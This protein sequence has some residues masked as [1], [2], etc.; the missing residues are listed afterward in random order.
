MKIEIETIKPENSALG[1][2]QQK[3]IDSNEENSKATKKQN[4]IS[5]CIQV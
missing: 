2:M 3:M 4:R 1:Q 5:N